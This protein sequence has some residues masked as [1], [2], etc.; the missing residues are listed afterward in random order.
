MYLCRVY[1]DEKGLAHSHGFAS[2]DDATESDL[3]LWMPRPTSTPMDT[4]TAKYIISHVGSGFC[5]MIEQE[6]SAMSWMQPGGIES[7]VYSYR[8]RQNKVDP[9][10]SFLL[11][12]QRPFEISF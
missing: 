5:R 10:Y 4:S 6:K 8:V 3:K 2:K 9:L 11:F 12:S 7:M 1:Y